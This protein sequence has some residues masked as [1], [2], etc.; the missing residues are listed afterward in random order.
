MDDIARLRASPNKK[1]C[2]QRASY[3]DLDNAFSDIWFGAGNPHGIHRA[4]PSEVLHMIQKGWHDYSL[5]GFFGILSDGPIRFLE[6]LAKRMSEQLH[7]QSDR[8]LPRTK[9]PHGI[10]TISQLQAHEAAGVILLLV[11]SLHCHVGWDKDNLS[12]KHSFVNS[13]FVNDKKVREYRTLFET[14]LCMEAWYKLK[15][16]P[17]A[18]IDSGQARAAISV[19]M[20]K[21]VKTVDRQE[22]MGMDLT[23]THA[24]LHTPVDISL[25]GCAAN[26]DS[27][28]LESTHKDTCK[29]PSKLTQK[30]A[31]LLE[32]QVA[33]RLSESFILDTAKGMHFRPRDVDTITIVKSKDVGGL[34]RR[35]KVFAEKDGLSY[36]RTYL[37]EWTVR[38]DKR[39]PSRG[40]PAVAEQFIVRTICKNLEASSEDR[41]LPDLEITCF[42]T[43]KT[44][45]YIYHAHPDCHGKTWYDPVSK[46]T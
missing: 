17:K 29:K 20:E 35:L 31:D 45:G 30:R 40:F 44:D 32:E 11:L 15:K 3:H 5:D 1:E 8:D 43:H 10:S 39:S 9:F 36:K 19:A 42:T 34:M 2:L 41:P 18:Q 46:T 23:K 22:G 12:E 14:L 7:H 21:Y 24:P 6:A 16:V 27:G 13:S 33:K 28:P 26:F 38:K 4:T 37:S 25:F